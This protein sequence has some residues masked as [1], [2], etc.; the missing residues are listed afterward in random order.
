MFSGVYL[1]QPV[2]PSVRV[3]V[4]VQDTTFCQSAGGAIKSHSV[5]VLVCAWF[6][7]FD[8]NLHDAN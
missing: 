7:H 3:S 1:N 2:C 8:P 6:T 4:C 5:T